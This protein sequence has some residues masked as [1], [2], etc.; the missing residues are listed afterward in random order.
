[1]GDIGLTLNPY[2]PVAVEESPGLAA[3][4]LFLVLAALSGRA[5]RRVAA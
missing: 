4:F 1:M 2:A 5:F 3:A